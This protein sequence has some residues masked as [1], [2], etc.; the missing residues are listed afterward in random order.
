MQYQIIHALELSSLIEKVCER[1]EDDW[2]PCGGPFTFQQPWY[3]PDRQQVLV[4]Q[5]LIKYGKAQ[6]QKSGL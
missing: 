2:I 6:A 5:A 4:A 3:D 1:V